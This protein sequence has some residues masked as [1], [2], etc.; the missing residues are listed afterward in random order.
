MLSNSITI[1]FLV[2]LGSALQCYRC[3]ESK[4]DRSSNLGGS[5]YT[6]DLTTHID[7]RTECAYCLVKIFPKKEYKKD[8]YGYVL[9]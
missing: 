8:D 3:Q 5:C 1:L 2:H 6:P 7:N 9:F 4:E